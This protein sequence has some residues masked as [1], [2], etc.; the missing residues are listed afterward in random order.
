LPHLER[1]H[2]DYSRYL[3]AL[4]E[5]GP[6]ELGQWID[7]GDGGNAITY[8]TGGWWNPE[9]WGTWTTEHAGLTID[10]GGEVKTDLVMDAIATAFVNERNPAV[11]VE[12]LVNDMPA[13]EWNFRF[14]NGALEYQTYRM[15]LSQKA[16][17]KELP[18][19][20]R[21]RVMGAGSPA[22]VGLSGD[23]RLLGLALRRLR[24]LPQ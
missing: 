21:F 3:A 11:D 18:V 20:I 24:L 15:M 10:F 8:E 9:P 16:L 4:P 12:V 1:F 6:Y 17:N 22:A 5:S 7:F 14:K 13:G 2:I 23:S 19:V